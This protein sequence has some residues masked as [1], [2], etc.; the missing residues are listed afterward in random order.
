MTLGVETVPLLA[1]W[2]GEATLGFGVARELDGMANVAARS[3]FLID[4]DTVR[5]SWLLD[6]DLPDIAAILAAATST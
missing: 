2:A 1:D 5:A 4:G 6:G 3:A